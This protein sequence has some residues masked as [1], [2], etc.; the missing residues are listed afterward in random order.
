MS[1]QRQGNDLILS[2]HDGATPLRS[3]V[4]NSF[5]ADTSSAVKTLSDAVDNVSDMYSLAANS[6]LN[7]R[8]S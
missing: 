3:T 1:I 4:M 5:G 7:Q 8:A 2:L 6:D